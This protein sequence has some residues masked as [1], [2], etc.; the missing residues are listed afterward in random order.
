M[1][2]EQNLTLQELEAEIKLRNALEVERKLNKILYAE[3]RVELLV[4]GLIGLI[5]AAFVGTIVK[6]VFIQ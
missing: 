3:K 4:Y 5:L 2:S 6:V 1:M